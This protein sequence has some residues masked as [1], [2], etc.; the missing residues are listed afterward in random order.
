[1]AKRELR[2]GFEVPENIRLFVAAE[3]PRDVLNRLY[4]ALEVLRGRYGGVRWEPASKLHFTLKFLGSV[5]DSSVPGIET[6]LRKAAARAPS[7][8]ARFDGAGCF[9][10]AGRPRVVW[11]G[12]ELGSDE[13]VSLQ[14][15]V[16][17]E[18]S[19]IGYDKDRRQ[20]KPHLTVG[21]IKSRIRLS[22]LA[23]WVPPNDEFRIDHLVL[24]QSKLTSQGSFYTDLFSCPLE[25]GEQADL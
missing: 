13:M 1:M 21:R 3:P 18:L 16:D 24:K 6:G 22:S 17:I 8:R 20:F 9:P 2:A 5:P 7:F 14:K 11:V 23:G 25:I 12:L 19:A 10:S 4:L 15:A